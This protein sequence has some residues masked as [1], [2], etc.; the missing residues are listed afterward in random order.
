MDDAILARLEHENMLL[1]IRAHCDQV[2]GALVRIHGG[3]GVFGSGIPK[4]LFNQ[5][6]S[7]D[8]ATDDE[9]ASGAHDLA[10]R[11]APFCVVLRRGIDD[12]L[13]AGLEA[14]GLRRD[15]EIMPGLA[16]E[17]AGFTAGE[18]PTDLAIRAVEGEADLDDVVSV[19]ASGFEMPAAMIRD[20]VGP[21]PW[22][23][24]G[25]TLYL[26]T[27]AAEPVTVGLGVRT[28]PTIGIYWIAT[29]PEAR[30]RGFG[31]A[32]TRRVVAAGAAAGCDVAALQASDMGRPIYERIG[33]RTVIEYD[34]YVG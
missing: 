9:L 28:G 3:V 25:W 17:I 29:V 21:E 26:G 2:P 7:D 5:V 19:A 27:S 14:L 23:R 34:I 10:S 16:R 13:A 4:P 15:A 12:H 30:G 11:G 31:E 1:W 33:F 32:M 20:F 22:R 6:I 24:P 18:L 8:G